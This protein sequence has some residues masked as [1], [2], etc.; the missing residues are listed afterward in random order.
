VRH[1]RAKLRTF[2]PAFWSPAITCSKVACSPI[3]RIA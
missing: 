2:G 1:F 3:I